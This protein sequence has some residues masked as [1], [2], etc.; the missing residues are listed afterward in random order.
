M[1]QFFHKK[2]ALKKFLSEANQEKVILGI[3]RD[4]GTDVNQYCKL[5]EKVSVKSLENC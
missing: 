3:F 2:I 4:V 1:R 5:T